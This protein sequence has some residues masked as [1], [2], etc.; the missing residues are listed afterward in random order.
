MSAQLIPARVT[1]MLSVSTVT[2]LLV[3]L[4]NKDSPEMEH[5][6][7]VEANVIIMPLNTHK[8]MI[9]IYRFLAI[10]INSQVR[11]K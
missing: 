7:K 4:V 2:V 11:L 9:N 1:Q 6:V 8:K 5:L 3:A 10:S